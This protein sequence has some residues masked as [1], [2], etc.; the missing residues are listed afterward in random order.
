M[1]KQQV[2]KAEALLQQAFQD[3]S[4]RLSDKDAEAAG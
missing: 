2:Q 3:L 4:R 1:L